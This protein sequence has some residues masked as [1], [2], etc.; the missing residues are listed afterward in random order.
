MLNVVRKFAQRIKG[1]VVRVYVDNN[2]ALSY[3]R[4]RGA[5]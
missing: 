5:E 2:I 4:K 3:L 1:R